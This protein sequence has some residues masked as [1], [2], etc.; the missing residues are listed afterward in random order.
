MLRVPRFQSFA[1]QG[2]R[3]LGCA[4]G[5]YRSFSYSTFRNSHQ[6]SQIPSQSPDHQSQYER[7]FRYS[8]GCWLWDEEEQ[9]RLRYA[10]F[11][12][13]R[14]QHLAAAAV[15]ARTC[16]A[17]AKTAEGDYSKSFRL[18]M[19]NGATV[20]AKISR[21]FEAPEY[22]TT[23]SEV[24]TM[25]FVRS[26]LNI[27]TPHVYA[28]SADSANS[29][30]VEY[31]LMA[32]LEGS[33]L[34][35]IWDQLPLEER[36]PILD[37]LVAV[38]K[39]LSSVFF[40][41]YGSIYFASDNVPGAVPAEITGDVPAEAK[42]QFMQRYSIGPVTDT[43]FWRKERAAMETDRGPWKH[44]LEYLLAL[45]SCQEQ[46]IV[47][48]ASANTPSNVCAYSAA[49]YSPA[50]HLSLLQKFR[51]YLLPDEPAT[52]TAPM[53]WHTGIHPGNF[54]VKDGRITGITNWHEV[55]ARPLILQSST[56][57]GAVLRG[58]DLRTAA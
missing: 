19:D 37:D 33:P 31:I 26:V 39:K 40:N 17:M 5:I 16:I 20:I 54:F 21:P 6:F 8:S 22:Y 45:A 24:A 11:D 32:E 9:M 42:D 7:F 57:R 28:W 3:S 58:E 44:P 34:E 36:I 41:R 18:T 38:E 55:W 27:P 29:V 23:A 1:W 35:E 53:I 25:D 50:A 12:V 52:T 46:W 14:L 2:L 10:P 30:G 48:H 13:Q 43:D 51:P 49:Q 15:G 56:P 47:R 4:S